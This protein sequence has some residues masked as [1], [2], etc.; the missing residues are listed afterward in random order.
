M[1]SLCARS[2]S[3]DARE[4]CQ[5]CLHSENLEDGETSRMCIAK[6]MNADPQNWFSAMIQKQA[7]NL[8]CATDPSIPFC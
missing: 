2:P 8:Q 5:A 1:E 4:E 3:D 6:L 7:V